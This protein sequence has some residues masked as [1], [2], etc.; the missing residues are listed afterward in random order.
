[1]TNDIRWHTMTWDRVSFGD[2]YQTKIFVELC[3]KVTGTDG[4][5]Y[6]GSD[7]ENGIYVNNRT[8]VGVWATDDEWNAILDIWKTYLEE[9]KSEC[10]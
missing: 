8:N 1:M 4:V 3:K 10:C 2:W 7:D 5:L 6:L 9:E